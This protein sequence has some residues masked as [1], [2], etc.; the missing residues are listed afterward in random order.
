MLRKPIAVRPDLLEIAD[1]YGFKFHTIDNEPYW[2]EDRYYTLSRF[3]VENDLEQ[4]TETLHQMCLTLA[5]E[6]VNSPELMN[7]LAIPAHLHNWIRNSWNT[8]DL[9]LYGRFDFSYDGINPPKLLEYNAQTPTSLYEAAFFQHIWMQNQVDRGLL[10]KNVD[11]FNSIQERLIY[12]FQQL[13]ETI[14]A[15]TLYFSC[16]KGTEED[17]GTVDYLRDCAHQAGLKTDFI[18]VEDIGTGTLNKDLYLIN[19]ENLV[20]THIFML[21]PFEYMF[22]DVYG[23]ILHELKTEFIEPPW[24]AVLSNKGILPLLWER[25]P[26]CPYLLP[27]YFVGEEKADLGENYVTKPIFGREGEGIKIFLKEHLLTENILPGATTEIPLISQ[28]YAEL[29]KFGDHFTMFGSWVV[30]HNAAGIT[31]R[32]DHSQITKD[33]AYFIPHVFTP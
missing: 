6:I 19:N 2:I 27:C 31:I 17:R 14:G 21:Y 13:A 26:D 10:P 15:E 7:K 11:Q 32:E 1:Q 4:A 16:C 20:I 5:N 33:T 8:T 3:Q 24:K 9:T 28:Q 23:K 22:D 25:Y 12:R 18:Y 29:P 30:G